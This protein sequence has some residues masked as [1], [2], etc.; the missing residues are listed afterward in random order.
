V[1]LWD[2][3]DTTTLREFWARLAATKG[4]RAVFA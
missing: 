3:D 2:L 1:G 4:R